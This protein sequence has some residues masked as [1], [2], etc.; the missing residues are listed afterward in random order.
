MSNTSCWF[1][2]LNFLAYV[3]G[4]SGKRCSSDSLFPS[5]HIHLATHNYAHTVLYLIPI[6][7]VPWICLQ[8][9]IGPKRVGRVVG[10]IIWAQSKVVTD[11]RPVVERR[12]S[13]EVALTPSILRKKAAC[14]RH[15]QILNRYYIVRSCSNRKVGKGNFRDGENIQNHLDF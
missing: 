14:R 5:K 10:Q 11:S 7:P 9:Y 6:D 15:T 8:I 2:I 12:R 1:F 3:Y 13:T 4:V